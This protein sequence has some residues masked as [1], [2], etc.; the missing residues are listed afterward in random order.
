LPQ[1]YDLDLFD[2]SAWIGVVPFRM[3]QVQLRRFSRLRAQTFA[4]MNVRT[5]I[6]ERKSGDAGVYFFSLDA[7]SLPAVFGARAW[8]HLPYFWARMSISPESAG[9]I[10]YRSTRLFSIRGAHLAVRYRPAPQTGALPPSYPGT[11]EHFLTERYALFTHW[12]N[13]LLRGDIHHLQWTLRPA[14]AEWEQLNMTKA[15]SVVLP[16]T[17]PLLHF[18]RQLDVLAW[19]PHAI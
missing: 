4:E 17:V 16:P 14:E 13:T 15:Q 5:Y 1:G 8:F 18:S 11:I 12:G 6:R 2:G 10:R 19:P 7:A 9:W 3:E